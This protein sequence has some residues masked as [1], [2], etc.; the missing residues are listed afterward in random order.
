MPTHLFAYGT[1]RQPEVQRA[2]FGR[3]LDGA[4]DAVCGY[5]LGALQITDPDVIAS[6]GSD[7]HPVLLP[8]DDRG[9][10]V[11]GT[12]FAISDEDLAAADD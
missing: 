10:Q 8:S 2:V 7:S 5:D 9:Q 3:V 1:L 11:A 4:E 12:V 6:S